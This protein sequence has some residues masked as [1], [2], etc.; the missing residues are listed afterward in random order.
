MKKKQEN[1]RQFRWEDNFNYN[2]ALQKTRMRKK[3]QKLASDII[4]II[5]NK[6]NNS[7]NS[8]QNNN[9]NG[10]YN[11]NN[12]SHINNIRG[13]IAKDKKRERSETITLTKWR[14][15]IIAI[16]QNQWRM[17]KN[18]RTYHMLYYCLLPTLMVKLSFDMSLN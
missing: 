3:N 13:T 2:R 14:L 16:E 8:K 10:S 11:N 9:N 1:Y 7:N 18:K 4:V 17:G 5:M 15:K 12:I 6:Y